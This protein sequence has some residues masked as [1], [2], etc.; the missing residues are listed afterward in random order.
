MTFA[1]IELSSCVISDIV[2]IRGNTGPPGRACET[3]R[4][5]LKG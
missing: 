3:D 4:R 1:C 5:T 2:L